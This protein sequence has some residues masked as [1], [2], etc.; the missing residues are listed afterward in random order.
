MHIIFL[1]ILLILL[2]SEGYWLEF[3]IPRAY[4][5]YTVWHCTGQHCSSVY[6]SFVC[7]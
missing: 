5:V 7:R 3:S 2:P 4:Y 6:V 1:Q